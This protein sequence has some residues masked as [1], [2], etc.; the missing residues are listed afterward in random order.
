VHIGDAAST[1]EYRVVHR[2]FFKLSV[3]CSVTD[4]RGAVD[5]FEV[6]GERNDGGA[7]PGFNCGEA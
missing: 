4:D 5:R 3:V 1:F 6:V 2:S 7:S